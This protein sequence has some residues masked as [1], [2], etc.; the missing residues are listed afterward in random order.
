VPV[1]HFHDAGNCLAAALEVGVRWRGL[2]AGNGS[3]S[4]LPLSPGS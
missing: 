2:L 3:S 1:R 4:G